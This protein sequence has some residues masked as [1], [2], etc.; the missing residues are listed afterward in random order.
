MSRLLLIIVLISF[1]SISI[2][3]NPRLGNWCCGWNEGLDFSTFPPTKT[4]SAVQ[5]TEGTTQIS[6]LNGNLI[7][8]FYS[9]TVYNRNHQVMSNGTGI[10]DI[11]GLC[12]GSIVVPKPESDTQYYLFTSDY[13]GGTGWIDVYYS[14]IDMSLQSG[15]G[16]VTTKNILLRQSVSTGIAATH[17][18]NGKDVWLV[19]QGGTNSNYYAYQITANGI[20][21]AVV[22]SL[23]TPHTQYYAKFSPTGN[24]YATW[25]EEINYN[26]VK[27]TILNFNKSS[28][29]LTENFDIVDA[30]NYAFSF[31]PDGTKFY[32]SGEEHFQQ[33]DVTSR[34]I[35]NLSTNHY[36]T[37]QLASDGRI[38]L[39]GGSA[40]NP[41]LSVIS[42]PN[43][44]GIACNL[45]LL[46][47]QFNQFFYHFPTFIESNPQ[48][49][50]LAGLYT[51]NNTQ[52]TA[53][54][55][56]NSFTDAV[57]ALKCGG[58]SDAVTFD[59]ATGTYNEQITIPYITGSSATDTITFR[60]ASGVNTDVKLKS[61]LNR[62]TAVMILDTTAYL[63]FYDM[64]IENA[65]VQSFAI[66]DTTMHCIRLNYCRNLKFSGN[67]F[68]AT[69]STATTFYYNVFKAQTCDTLQITN[70]QF[71][72]G[73]YSCDL[74]NTNFALVKDNYLENFCMS[75]ISA[76]SFSDGILIT[77]NTLT[78]YSIR[79]LHG[80]NISSSTNITVEKNRI[81]LISNGSYENTNGL[82][83]FATTSL[84]NI[85][86]NNMV[87]IQSNSYSNGIRFWNARNSKAYN[88]TFLIKGNAVNEA[89]N[90]MIHFFGPHSGNIL[91]NNIFISYKG[92]PVVSISSSSISGLNLDY[93]TYYTTSTYFANR[94]TSNYYTTAQWKSTFNQDQHSIFQDVS[95]LSPT[96]LH[97]QTG[98]DFLKVNNPILQVTDDIDG[99]IRNNTNPYCGADEIVASVDFTV[100]GLCQTYLTT[101]QLSNTA[102]IQSVAWNFG[103]SQT[104]TQLNPTH[105]YANAGTYTITL[106]VTFTDNSTQTISKTIE[107]IN[108]PTNI[109]IEH[110]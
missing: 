101:F 50:T 73:T 107:I 27:T 53:S 81:N 102:D 99:E 23:F 33:Y 36:S 21:S 109:L 103:D 110:D 6:N 59:V 88:N 22:S 18:S 89:S 55:N 95:F 66:T 68:I 44:S 19:L 16:E 28:G 91:Q 94:Y 80:I 9:G 85:F 83:Y 39:A 65:R 70:N 29:I 90:G 76:N 52:P 17:H 14:I 105:T 93:N 108:K 69:N 30:A 47:I 100:S 104:S 79:E 31:S 74:S 98:Q 56:F 11:G 75:G 106:E 42:E 57:E 67:K 38:Y 12:Q 25:I 82:Q 54:R 71:L 78:G 77:E 26:W 13:N 15:L 5:T 97:L 46:N 49:P 63:R 41:I 62:Q 86:R 96:D 34:E 45:V 20:T 58:I 2:A 51:I 87:V 10:K 60:S 72:N 48:C 8:Y 7:C 64:T 43:Q 37:L 1:A 24:H 3:Q 92:N 4:F 61:T 40:T 32:F 84:S 35:T